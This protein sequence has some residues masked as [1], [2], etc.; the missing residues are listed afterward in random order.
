MRNNYYSGIQCAALVILSLLLGLGGCSSHSVKVP[1]PADVV[2]TVPISNM[3]GGESSSWTAYW[4]GGQAPY[5]IAW[6]FGGGA[7]NIGVAAAISP[8][9]AESAW[10][11]SDI[12]QIYTVVATVTD[13]LGLVGFATTSVTIGASPIPPPT[14][15]SM[16]VSG[17]VLTVI[18]SAYNGYT[19][20]VSV[21]N[22]LG[23]TVDQPT[24]LAT[25]TGAAVF[26]FSAID[27]FAGAATTVDVV[28]DDGHGGTASGTS[29][30]IVISA[31]FTAFEANAD[32]LYAIP[33]DASVAVDEP[34]T[35]LIYTGETA[36][37]FYFVLGVGVVIDGGGQLVPASHNYGDVGGEKD[38]ADGVWEGITTD[39][40]FLVLPDMV[41]GPGADPEGTLPVGSVRYDFNISPLGGTDQASVSGSLFNFQV[42]YAIAGEKI[43]SFQEFNGVNRTY[44]GDM[45]TGENRFWSAYVEG[46]ITVAE[47]G[48]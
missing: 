37:P 10:L 3:F 4:I 28:I 38:D 47:K 13:T 24:K 2:L 43:I 26:V 15:D 14:I 34:V 11:D 44:Y 9:N 22:H 39:G 48:S 27:Q 33:L 30:P 19:V 46:T 32:T 16:V 20:E 8:A 5:T 21:S 40:G 31:A 29:D 36:H 41:F 1:L 35:I 25:A 45:A 42:V 12:E 6:D 7:D 17:N 18:A 23:L